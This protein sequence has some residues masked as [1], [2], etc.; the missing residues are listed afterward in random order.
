M[1]KENE[2]RILAFN[3]AQAELVKLKRHVDDVE[4]KYEKEA[5]QHKKDLSE[6]DTRHSSEVV[7]LRKQTHGNRHKIITY[8]FI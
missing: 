8:N 2:K 5:G 3:V 1:L 6:K 4:F 7:E